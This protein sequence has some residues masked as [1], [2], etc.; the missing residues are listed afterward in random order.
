MTS[1]SK[2][3]NR[4]GNFKGCVDHSV[5]SMKSTPLPGCGAGCLNSNPAMCDGGIKKGG[6][7][8]GKRKGGGKMSPGMLK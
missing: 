4:D 3:I 5:P 6:S 1:M 7:I 2:K 8:Q